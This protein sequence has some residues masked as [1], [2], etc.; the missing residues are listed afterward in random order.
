[1]GKELKFEKSD[2]PAPV[3]RSKA[4]VIRES[5]LTPAQKDKYLRD[6]GEIKDEFDPKKVSFDVYATVRKIPPGRNKAMTLYP[7]AVGVKSATLTEWD[8]IFKNF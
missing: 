3:M 5:G 7:N 6:I 4:D 2:G 1:M 8:E